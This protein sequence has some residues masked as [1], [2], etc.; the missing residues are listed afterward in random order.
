MVEMAQT[1]QKDWAVQ[2]ALA[3]AKTYL[4]LPEVFRNSV[5]VNFDAPEPLHPEVSRPEQATARAVVSLSKVLPSLRANAPG[6]HRLTVNTCGDFTSIPGD[7]GTIDQNR[8]V[9]EIGLFVKEQDGSPGIMPD[10]QLD[11][12]VARLLSVAPAPIASR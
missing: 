3:L 7:C 1:T 4:V 12:E 10:T 8:T 2:D 6:L 9:M 11:A 5:T